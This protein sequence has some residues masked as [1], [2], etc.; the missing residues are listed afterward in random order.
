MDDSDDSDDTYCLVGP[1]WS[2]RPVVSREIMG[3]NPIRGASFGA[4]V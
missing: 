1:V 4:L 3:S 2:G